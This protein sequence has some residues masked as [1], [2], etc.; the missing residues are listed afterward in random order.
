M[1]LHIKNM[2]S[3]RCKAIALQELQTIGFD[4]RCEELGRITVAG[5]LNSQELK[6]LQLRLRLSGLELMD[7]KKT[8]ISNEMKVIIKE[9]LSANEDFSESTISSYLLNKLNRDYPYL[10]KIFSE[11]NKLT[12]KQYI[13]SERVKKVKELILNHTDK[14][15]DIS[16]KL[17]YSSTAHLCN[18]FKRVTG[19]TP[20][21]FRSNL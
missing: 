9:I 11:R 1:V 7:D 16:N 17:H 8:L 2:L 13:I 3:S 5:S 12:L 10:A 19:F 15:S 14:L 20:K 21:I 4:S 18:E 6:R